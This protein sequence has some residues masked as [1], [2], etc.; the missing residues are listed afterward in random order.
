MH[1][2]LDFDN[3]IVNYDTLFHQVALEKKLIPA[4]LPV[5]RIVVRDY[6]HSINQEE[7]WTTL[8]GDVYGARM[9]EASI[10]FGVLSFIQRTQAAGHTL[11]IISH[12]TKHPYLGPAYDLHATAYAWIKCHLASKKNP[13]FNKDHIF[14]ELT[15]EEK[16]MRIKKNHCD[17]FIDDLPEILLSAQFPCGVRRILF[18]PKKNHLVTSLPNIQIVES[19]AEC[20]NCLL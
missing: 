1:I 2:G 5:D 13:F 7:V 6:L 3:T 11:T 12:K 14:F 4:S 18:D 8:Q 15:K 10:Y 16:L 9:D 19:W 20:E 17:I